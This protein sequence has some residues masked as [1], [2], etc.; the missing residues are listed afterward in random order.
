MARL[1]P[2]LAVC[3]V[4]LLLYVSVSPCHAAAAGGKPSAVVLPVSKDGATQQYVTV[5]RQRTPQVPVRA[6]LDL[7]G[8]T[9]WVDCDAGYASSSYARV[10]CGSRP[11]RLMKY[12]ECFNS[13]FG[14]PSPAC[15]N[16]T[17]S[18]FPG[19]AVT[20]V[21]AGGTIITDVLSLPTTFR[22]APGPLAT[23]PAFL[24]TC[25]HTYLT[26]GLA[27][28]ATGMASLSRAR[29]ALPTQLAKTFGF[30]RRFALCLPPASAAGFVVFGDAPRVFQPGVD[31]SKSL[32]YTPLLVNRVKTAGKYTT[33]EIGIDYLIGV[34]GI[35]VNGRAVPLN[36]TLLTI[37]KNGV[38]GTMLS[39][40]SPY[41][42]LET[43]IY[44]AVVDAFAAETAAK[45]PR[46]PA[47]APFELCYDGSRV[48]STRAGPAVPTIELVLQS[49]GAAASWVVFGANSMV[50]AKGG[51]LC[52][53]M[54]DDDAID[55]LA[56]I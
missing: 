54:V 1:P 51:A 40:A 19:N 43:S 26:E 42:V 55:I 39:T 56:N 12:R 35:K 46:A 10:P 33:G 14:E 15:L 5:F 32:I 31:L 52:L 13:C 50:T 34:S 25:A 53:A 16:D 36:T 27:T 20:R 49:E 22:P 29:F 45:I 23:A 41:T 4:A 48:G 9:L 11:C 6:V 21:T 37:D 17:C 47:V 28:G 18:A 8:A 3:S 7:A 30:S 24:F 44:R 38:G 2:P